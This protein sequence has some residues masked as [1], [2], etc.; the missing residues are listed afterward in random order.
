[1]MLF[2]YDDPPEVMVSAAFDA[3]ATSTTDAT[4]AETV[5]IAL[6]E[7]RICSPCLIIGLLMALVNGNLVN[8]F[9]GLS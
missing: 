5:A 9:L 3:G 2:A 1:M 8:R 7:R 4:R 6:A